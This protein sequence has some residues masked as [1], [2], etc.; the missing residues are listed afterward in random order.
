MRLLGEMVGDMGYGH[1]MTMD[2]TIKGPIRQRSADAFGYDQLIKAVKADK[3]EGV[4]EVRD[5]VSKA[6]IG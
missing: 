5:L 4:M 3:Y 6:V 1:R 2:I